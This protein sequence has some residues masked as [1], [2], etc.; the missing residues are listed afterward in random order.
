MVK[1]CNICGSRTRLKNIRQIQKLGKTSNG[2]KVLGLEEETLVNCAR[3][4]NLLGGM[5]HKIY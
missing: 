4:G 3:C 5:S 2:I 1:A